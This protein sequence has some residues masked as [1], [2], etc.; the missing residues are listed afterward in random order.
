[1]R[2]QKRRCGMLLKSRLKAVCRLPL[3]FVKAHGYLKKICAGNLFLTE[4]VSRAYFHIKTI[5]LFGKGSDEKPF[6]NKRLS[7]RIIFQDRL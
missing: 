7:S 3:N 5:K 4:K 6:L 2:R 1:M